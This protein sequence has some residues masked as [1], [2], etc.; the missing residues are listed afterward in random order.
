[1]LLCSSGMSRFRDKFYVSVKCDENKKHYSLHLQIGEMRVLFHISDNKQWKSKFRN[2]VNT[3]RH[4]NPH[5]QTKEDATVLL[6]LYYQIAINHANV[7]EMTKMYTYS[8]KKYCREFIA[9]LINDQFYSYFQ[10]LKIN[11]IKSAMSFDVPKLPELKSSPAKEL[12][13]AE[14]QT[15]NIPETVKPET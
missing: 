5:E 10:K 4:C 8:K 9:K 12:K 2:N 3:E 6:C 14:V 11:L 7:T 15:E 13:S 1:M